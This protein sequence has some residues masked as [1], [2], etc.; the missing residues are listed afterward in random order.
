MKTTVIYVHGNGGSAKEAEHYA[1]LFEGCDVIGFDYKAKTPWEAKEEFPQFFKGYEDVILI[2]NSIGAYFAMHALSGRNI[3][4]AYFISPIVDMENLINNMMTWANVNEEDLRDKGQIPT[5]FGETLSWKYLCYVK[6][7]PITWEIPTKILY[8]DK[9]N[10]TPQEVITAF[11]K[12]IGAEL[13]VMKDGEHWFHT[14]KQMAFL[15]EWI[16][17]K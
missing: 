3:K 1:P 14:D 13:T 16:K 17:R 12:R 8:G 11:A 9:D 6:E 15:D 5:S 4:K 2:A 7:N 10:L